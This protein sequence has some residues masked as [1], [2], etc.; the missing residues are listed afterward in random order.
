MQ[1]IARRPQRPQ[2]YSRGNG[3]TVHQACG[4][5]WSRDRPLEGYERKDLPQR[6]CDKGLDDLKATET[7]GRR[8]GFGFRRTRKLA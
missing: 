7:D 1:P 5:D 8:R 2:E 3:C 6:S 4:L